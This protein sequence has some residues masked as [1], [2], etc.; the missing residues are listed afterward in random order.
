MLRL[1]RPWKPPPSLI[2]PPGHLLSLCHPSPAY[3]GRLCSGPFFEYQ[4]CNSEEC[5]GP[6]EDFRAQQCAKRNSYYTH[7]NAK[8]SWLP[9]E[10]EDGEPPC[11]HSPRPGLAGACVP[12]QLLPQVF[13]S[14][15][16]RD[17]VV[18]KGTLQSCV[19]PQTSVQACAL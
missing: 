19:W 18:P 9:Y 8:H 7:Q 1:S 16:A 12:G 14:V 4:V 15:K 6:Y 17:V 13:P 10:S 3:G 2:N 11:S 5:P